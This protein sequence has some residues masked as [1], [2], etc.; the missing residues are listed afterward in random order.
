M[1]QE[2]GSMS[3]EDFGAA[4]DLSVWRDF[5][6]LKGAIGGFYKLEFGVSKEGDLRF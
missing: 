2:D 5:E 4:E 6:I 3:F 1:G